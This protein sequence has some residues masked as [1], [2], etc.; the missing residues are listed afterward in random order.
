MTGLD[1]GLGALSAG[2]DS[3][4]ENLYALHQGIAQTKSGV[5]QAM[6][7]LSGSAAQSA[8]I[9]DGIDKLSKGAQML[10]GRIESG[11]RRRKEALRRGI[12]RNRRSSGLWAAASTD[13]TPAPL[14]CP[15][16]SPPISTG[17]DALIAQNKTLAGQLSALSASTTLTERAKGRRTEKYTRCNVVAG[18]AASR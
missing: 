2:A 12:L 9:T 6:S 16:A 17:V 10:F 4:T 13:L 7:A 5:D 3:L 11:G 15:K 18:C 8:S 1:S 14:R